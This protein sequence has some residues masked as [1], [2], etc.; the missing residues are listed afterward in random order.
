MN[1]KNSINKYF[2]SIVNNT[3]INFFDITLTKLNNKFIDETLLFSQIDDK[4]TDSANIHIIP[5]YYNYVKIRPKF[6]WI[7]RMNKEDI[8]NS[9]MQISKWLRKSLSS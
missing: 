5:I 2:N 6:N 8:I 1:F 9:N 7:E 4:V 3:N